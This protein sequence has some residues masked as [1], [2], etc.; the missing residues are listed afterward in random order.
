MLRITA[1]PYT[2]RFKRPATTSR[3]ALHARQVV[4]LRAERNGIAG[5]G[6]CGPV[7]GLSRDDVVIQAQG[8][9]LVVRGERRPDAASRPESFH[10][11]ERRYGP[12]ARAFR[13]AEEVDPDR[14][15]AAFDD[16][17]LR[18]SVPKARP[19]PATRV[20]VERSE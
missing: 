9:E 3:G 10:R 11:L 2:L 15:E 20:R 8:D 7:P 18:L 5:W 17:L 19:R 12:F 4:L 13:F 16:G 14:I 1:I 6:E